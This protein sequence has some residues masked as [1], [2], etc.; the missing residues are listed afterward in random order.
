MTKN[1]AI[2]SLDYVEDLAHHYHLQALSIPT[3][4]LFCLLD[5]ITRPPLKDSGRLTNIKHNLGILVLD[6]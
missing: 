4:C 1:Q 2:Y 6:F 5:L 3:S